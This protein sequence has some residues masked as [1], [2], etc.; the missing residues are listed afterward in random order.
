MNFMFTRHPF[1][2]I[3]S[4]YRNKL[5]PNSTFE[6]AYHWQAEFGEKII[7]LYRY[8]IDELRVREK[9][10]RN[11]H[12]HVVSPGYDLTFSEFVRYL[13][14]EK[15]KESRF[16]NNIHWVDVNRVCSP[17]SVRYDVI[18][19]L[20]TIE[21]DAKY[22]LKLANVDDIVDFPSPDISSPTYSFKKDILEQY[23]EDV[24][25]EYVRD[26]YKRYL[27]DFELFGYELPP[28]ASKKLQEIGPR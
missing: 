17:C 21:D 4:S 18:G 28:V 8:N 12:E 9:K 6:R 27:L 15:N 1:S 3:L 14:D 16:F 23:L 25:A 2:R 22:I 26:L 7:K 5:D 19:K 10:N 11:K 13:G 24:P 20:E